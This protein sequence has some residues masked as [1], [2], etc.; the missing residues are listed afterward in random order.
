[1]GPGWLE[2]VWG[3]N[4]HADT[5]TKIVGNQP[6]QNWGKNQHFDHHATCENESW[7]Q[8]HT[9]VIMHVSNVPVCHNIRTSLCGL[10]YHFVLVHGDLLTH[11]IAGYLVITVL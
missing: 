5:C 10:F 11:Y 1:M 9:Y 8:I 2:F 7:W 4:I 3:I 6:H